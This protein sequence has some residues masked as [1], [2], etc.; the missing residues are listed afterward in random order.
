[1]ANFIG[2]SVPLH[3]K[4]RSDFNGDGKTDI[5][6][7]RP[8]NNY[9]YILRDSAKGLFDSVQFGSPGDKLVPGDYDGDGKTDIAVFRP[10]NGYWYIL[11]STNGQV[12]YIP[13][14][15]STDKLVPP[16][17]IPE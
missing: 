6:V 17:Y 10:S 7:F 2:V 3:K 9:W 11:N 16:A 4:T 5:A 1:M 12:Q 8:S 14:G 13:F 15:E